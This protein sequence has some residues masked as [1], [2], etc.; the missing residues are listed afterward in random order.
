MTDGCSPELTS[1]RRL[2][3]AWRALGTAIDVIG[4]G[5]RG[6]HVD[7]APVL[8]ARRVWNGNEGARGGTDPSPITPVMRSSRAAMG[9]AVRA[10]G[11]AVAVSTSPEDRRSQQSTIASMTVWN[12]AA[13][14]NAASAPSAGPS[15]TASP[16][17]EKSTIAPR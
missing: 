9:A 2:A 5:S 11:H 3:S 16:L 7:R 10:T 14:V 6:D 1:K 15:R 4:R 8:P 12:R 13:F 17:L